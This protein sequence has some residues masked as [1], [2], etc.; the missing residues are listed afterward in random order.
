MSTATPA[1]SAQAV[2]QLLNRDIG[3]AK[4][5]LELLEQE[6]KALNS[7]SSEQLHQLLTEKQ[8]LMAQFEQ[9]ATQRSRWVGFLMERTGLST[10]ECWEKL[11]TELDSSS[12][13][14]L[15]QEFQKLINECKQHNEINGKMIARGQKTLKQLLTIM[16]GQSVEAPELYNASGST[17]SQ[18]LSHTVVKA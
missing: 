9:S 18:N 3:F 12:L 16:R 11:L 10:E 4:K 15:W 5:L 14:Q 1:V 2:E 7:R 8:G 17:Q 13:P 6:H